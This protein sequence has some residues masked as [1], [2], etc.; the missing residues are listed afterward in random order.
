VVPEL[1]KKK[2]LR[3]TELKKKSEE[4]RKKKKE[5]YKLKLKDYV[6]RGEKW[7]KEAIAEQKKIIDLKRE[8]DIIN[9]NIGKTRRQLLCS[10]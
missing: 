6:A 4:E 5:E 3:N 2:E 9:K 10:S 8:V 7:Y 1:I